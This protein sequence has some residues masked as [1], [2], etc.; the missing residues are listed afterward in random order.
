MSAAPTAK[1][2]CTY[3]FI[4]MLNSIIDVPESLL[5]PGRDFAAFHH[6]HTKINW[7]RKQLRTQNHLCPS[8]DTST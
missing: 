6:R 3:E 8:E 2:A 1:K 4:S 5:I 7:I